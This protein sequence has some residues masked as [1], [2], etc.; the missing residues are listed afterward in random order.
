MPLPI[1]DEE[2]ERVTDQVFSL[3]AVYGFQKISMN[4]VAEQVGLS[5][6]TLYKYFK[7]KEDIA[8]GMVDRITYHLNDLPFTTSQGIEDVLTS[9]SSIY[10]EGV[11]I[12]AYFSTN[13]ITD[14]RNK[15]PVYY[16]NLMTAIRSTED[17][18]V[19]FYTQAVKENYCRDISL[20][21]ACSQICRTLPNIICP[22]YRA[23]YNFRLIELLKNYY[24]LM[25]C[26]MLNTP[27]LDCV[28]DK[29]TYSFI[30][31][32]LIHIL[33]EKFCVR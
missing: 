17:R 27:Y 23:K 8:R 18:F 16:D 30:E 25:L 11:L 26:Q 29:K 20:T 32:K 6:A 10:Y 5:K 22:E 1:S 33:N 24:K 15:F 4:K 21:L 28:D 2:K 3:F 14:L 13:F 31:D 12:A 9:L 7:S 19:K